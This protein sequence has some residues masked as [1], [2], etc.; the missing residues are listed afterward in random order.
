MGASFQMTG[1][2]SLSKDV[3]RK[4]N[5]Q[6]LIK[7]VSGF[8]QLYI[9]S[10]IHTTKQLFNT[11]TVIR[12]F[13]FCRFVFIFICHTIKCCTLGKRDSTKKMDKHELN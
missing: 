9:S 7:E 5:P 2:R 12:I 1:Q 8:F 3:A 10:L 11:H 4:I 13:N 6:Q